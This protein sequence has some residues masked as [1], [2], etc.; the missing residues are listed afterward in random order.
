MAS[1]ADEFLYSWVRWREACEHVHTAYRFWETCEPNESKF[2]FEVYL[3]ALD[4][5]EHAAL[6]HARRSK[7]LAAGEAASAARPAPSAPARR[8]AR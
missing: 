7:A 8:R 5:E 4:R 1:V 2:A 3:A 6:I